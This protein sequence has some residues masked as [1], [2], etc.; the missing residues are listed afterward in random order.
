MT[1]NPLSGIRGSSI[2][3]IESLAAG[4]ACVSTEEGARGF[5]TAGLSGLITVP[6]VESM[7]QPIIKL[8]GD[9]AERHR[10]EAAD[11]VGL[12]PFLWQNCAAIQSDLY[13]NLIEGGHA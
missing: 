13:R 10:I 2:K 7:A 12:A 3:L 5:I 11:T 6:D 8:L 9:A 4:R 1:L